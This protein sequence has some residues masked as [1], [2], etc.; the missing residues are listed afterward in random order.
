[1]RRLKENKSIYIPLCG[2]SGKRLIE[3]TRLHTLMKWKFAE[4][5]TNTDTLV[6]SISLLFIMLYINIYYLTHM[7]IV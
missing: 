3:E 4:M 6:A 1:V 2:K 5:H 7:T